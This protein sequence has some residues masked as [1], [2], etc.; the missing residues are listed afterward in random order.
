MN[1]GRE[2]VKREP[3]NP[4]FVLL[5]GPRMATRKNE[6]RQ[7]IMYSRVPVQNGGVILRG[8]VVNRTRNM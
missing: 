4:R 6:G 2:M 8:N 7:V 3:V 5:S 1:G